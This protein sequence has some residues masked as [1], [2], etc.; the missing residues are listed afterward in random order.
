M[1]YPFRFADKKNLSDSLEGGM[2][3]FIAT[4]HRLAVLSY[5]SAI[6]YAPMKAV[7]TMQLAPVT[8]NESLI[9][10]SLLDA[11]P[12]FGNETLYTQF[13]ELRKMLG[14]VKASDLFDGSR[15][16]DLPWKEDNTAQDLF[17][18]S[19]LAKAIHNRGATDFE[20]D[21][22]NIKKDFMRPIQMGISVLAAKFD[23]QEKSTVGRID[24][25]AKMGF[26]KKQDAELLKETYL[27]LY[28]MRIAESA[29]F[30]GEN[31]DVALSEKAILEATEKQQLLFNEFC[32]LQDAELVLL[33]SK[34]EGRE[35]MAD[36]IRNRQLQDA[37]C[38]E[39]MHLSRFAALNKV[40]Q[41]EAFDS[42]RAVCSQ[43]IDSIRKYQE[44]L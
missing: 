22:V 12:I 30:G 39:L 13:L 15:Y 26:F 41:R 18:K 1:T 34:R 11:K 31:D 10:P 42:H 32:K 8:G 44:A 35:S 7:P 3:S 4:P 29:D 2:G 17:Y 23:L 5:Q 40:T 19:I 6:S 33:K 25:L 27:D 43:T 9:A 14:S 20:K 36:L 16:S 38:E 28:K 24:A 37:Y 21:K